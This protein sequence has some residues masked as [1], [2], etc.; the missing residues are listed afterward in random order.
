MSGPRGP[1]FPDHL[2][3][4]SVI[5]RIRISRSPQRASAVRP[6]CD[7]DG[8]LLGRRRRGPRRGAPLLTDAARRVARLGED[9]LGCEGALHRG[10]AP[11][12]EGRAHR[13]EGAALRL[14]LVRWQ[15]AEPVASRENARAH[16]G[17]PCPRVLR[18]SSWAREAAQCLR[19]ERRVASWRY[20]D[21]VLLA[22]HRAT[23]ERATC[24]DALRS[25]SRSRPPCSSCGRGSASTRGRESASRSQ[26]LQAWL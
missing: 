25:W 19:R 16:F 18:P 5:C 15:V 13:G 22:C 4:G 1:A 23:R 17:R 24:C 7:S 26:S 2:I 8:P 21:A 20:E 9:E 12:D 6:A 11:Q 14:D 10:I 3:T